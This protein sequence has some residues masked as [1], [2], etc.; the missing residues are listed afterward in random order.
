MN[1][2]DKTWGMIIHLSVVA[3]YA[4][5]LA[6]IIAPIA[7]WQIKKDELEGIDQHGKNVSRFVISFSIYLAVSI[8]LIFVLIGIPMVAL[9]GI[10]M[11][12]FPIIAAIKASNG[13]IWEYPLAIRF[14]Q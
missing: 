1:Q 13:E 8:V 2:E 10:A 4:I 7:S 9:L 11:V 3:G 5:P 14:F 6:G 12:A